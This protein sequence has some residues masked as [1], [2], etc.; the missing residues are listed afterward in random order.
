MSYVCLQFFGSP[1]CHGTRLGI[2]LIYIFCITLL[3][4]LHYLMFPVPNLRP[5]MTMIG[6]FPASLRISFLSSYRSC[7]LPE[8]P[9]GVWRN[10][11][12]VPHLDSHCSVTPPLFRK[13]PCLS[14]SCQVQQVLSIKSSSFVHQTRQ[15]S[16]V[17]RLFQVQDS[18]YNPDPFIAV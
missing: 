8:I 12:S 1:Q 13:Q 7:R 3:V 15:N 16:S 14:R 6:I 2:P 18:I 9:H 11:Q 5:L 4:V 17:P 10:F